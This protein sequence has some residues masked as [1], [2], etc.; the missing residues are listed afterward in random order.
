MNSLAVLMDAPGRIALRPLE[1]HAL[2]ERDVLVETA[3]SG[4]STGTERLLFTGRMPSFPGLGYPLVP[5]YESVGRVVEAGPDAAQREGDWVFAPGAACYRDARGLFGATASR[6]IARGE[7]VVPLPES[8]GA[9]GTLLSLA[10]T[11]WHAL[12]GGPAPD[13]IVGHGVLGRLLARLAIA[14]GA[15]APTVWEAQPARR[16]G[17]HG[18]PVVEPILD[19]RRDYRAIVDASGD[20]AILDLLIAHLARGGEI[21]LAGFYER[22]MSFT[23]PPAFMK[24]ARMRIA[25]EFTPADL[26]AVAALIA[27]GGVSLSGLIS[28]MRP[29]TQA[30]DAYPQAFEDRGCLKMVLDWS[31]AQ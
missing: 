19:E 24:E 10:A 15:P 17:E 23:F 5:G 7:R 1:L 2:G 30:A 4:I 18:Y 8:L 11:A 29:A 21:C 22:P 27:S 3:W 9:D 16:C 28:H 6:L 13:L 14:R 26:A 20:P 31:T 25:A 12:E